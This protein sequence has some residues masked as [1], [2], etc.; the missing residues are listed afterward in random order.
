M[1]IVSAA[2][3][4]VGGGVYVAPITASVPSSASGT[5]TGFTSVGNI[6]DDGVTFGKKMD[7]NVVKA[8]GGAVVCVLDEGYT[9]TAKFKF[10]DIDNT[11]ALGLVFKEVTGALGSEI[12][13]KSG[14]GAS[15]PKIIV[16]D[17]IL[18]GNVLQRTVIPRGIVSDVGDVNHKDSE[19]LG[20]EVTITAMEDA[21]GY[22]KYQYT[23][24][25]SSGGGN[26]G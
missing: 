10:L 2:K 22:T 4:R 9:E 16:I 17:E 25:G 19:V 23:K 26:N 14:P 6:S 11:V 1:A 5:L 18:S 13:C 8:W 20:Y 21:S 3:P 12:V 7:S 15:D 24:S